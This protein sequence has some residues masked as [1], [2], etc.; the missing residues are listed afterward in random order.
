MT[1]RTSN[2]VGVKRSLSKEEIVTSRRIVNLALQRPSDLFNQSLVRMLLAVAFALCVLPYHRVSGQVMAPAFSDDF[3]VV[4][5]GSVGG[6]GGV[7]GFAPG[8]NNK[9][10]VSTLSQGIFAFNYDPMT[11]ITNGQRAVPQVDSSAN[12]LDGALGMAFHQDQTHGTVMYYAPHTNGADPSTELQI[13]RANDSNGNGIFGDSGDSLNQTII[14][15]LRARG[16]GGHRL[17]NMQVVNDTLYLNI[18]SRTQNGGVDTDARFEGGQARGGLQAGGGYSTAGTTS[19]FGEY[20]YTGAVNFVEDLNAIGSGTNAAG[21]S[22]PSTEEG[23]ARDV[24]MFTSDDPGKLRVYA[25]GFRNVFGMAVND[26]G[27]L[28]VS[29]N[30]NEWPD[31]LVPDR[32]LRVDAFRDDFGYQK[33]NG[34]IDGTRTKPDFTLPASPLAGMD[35]SNGTP[36]YSIRGT[37]RDVG[38]SAEAAL[39]S[40]FGYFQQNAQLD[41]NSDGQIDLT[42]QQAAAFAL[43]EPNSQNPAVTG[44]DFMPGSMQ[45]PDL[46]GDLV[47]GEFVHNELSIID[48]QTGEAQNF[49][50]GFSDPIDVIRDPFGNLLALNTGGQL[51]R[52]APGLVESPPEPIA[53]WSMNAAG[54]GPGPAGNPATLDVATAS[55]QG[56]LIGPNQ[57]LDPTLASEDHLWTFN[58]RG[59]LGGTND[60]YVT[61]NQTAPATM[62]A[63]GFTGGDTSY[64]ASSV[65]GIDG[66]LFFPADVYGD[67]LSMADSFSLEL[68][69]RTDGDQSGNGPMQ[70]LMQGESNFRYG[71]SLNEGDSGNVRFALTDSTGATT[72]LDITDASNRNFAD[73]EWHYLLATFDGAEGDHGQ[74][75]L[76]LLSESG[77]LDTTTL[78][79]SSTFAGLASGSDGNLLVGRNT[80]SLATNPRTFVGLIDELRISRGIISAEMALGAIQITGDFD[81]DG[82]FDCV[83]VDALV[84]AISSGSTEY[85]FDLTGDGLVDVNDL[86]SWL[87]E[88]GAAN[89][90]SG[91]A[92]LPGDANLDGAVDGA[93]FLVWNTS[94]FSSVSAWCS[95]DFNA[96]GAV[97]GLDF[98]IWN[99]NKFQTADAVVVPEPHV[100][101]WLI[102][103]C[104]AACCMELRYRKDQLANQTGTANHYAEQ[105]LQFNLMP[106]TSARSHLDGADVRLLGSTGA[107][108][109]GSLDGD[110]LV[111][112]HGHD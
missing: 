51:I 16:E 18:G 112:S 85:N 80:F 95:G 36:Y 78:D 81:R 77:T 86:A 111:T 60:E 88:A 40:A 20:A 29:E 68:F 50:T 55:G 52:I 34:F 91:N 31:Q 35:G 17:N 62:F 24:Q 58:S 54:S 61:S 26:Q 47:V 3:S 14:N 63:P 108:A 79:L 75:M 9:L 53:H 102:V 109:Q 84:L 73:G 39:A 104:L 110:R 59:Q 70:L 2:L 33:S 30:Q 101:V 93:D 5:L 49:V 90:A 1:E 21:F 38:G 42:E 99:D 10:Y 8:V 11:G 48:K 76:T 87:A 13:R 64:D 27:E 103:P 12:G 43:I 44:L 23:H 74:M 98:L 92:Y 100:F 57:H 106:S 28:F 96:D 6:N 32:I 107:D 19:A 82:D 69:F 4:T 71:L 83:D 46:E 89:L 7:L 94:K 66:A 37:Y 67:E 105:P 65:D 25:T 41:S 15:N 97:D 56:V 45:R 72:S 22:I